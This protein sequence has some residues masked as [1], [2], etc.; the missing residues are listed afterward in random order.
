[1]PQLDR[2]IVFTQIFWLFF[3]FAFLYITLTHFFLPTFLKSIK[4]RKKVV[5]E[6]SKEVLS[7][8]SSLVLKQTLLKQTLLKTLASMGDTSMKHSISVSPQHS[9]TDTELV[10]KKIGQAS[11]NTALYCSNHLLNSIP[12]YPK[13]FNLDCK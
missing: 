8:D 11:L 7:I 1:M 9:R 12:L 3:I 4:S 5:D 6:N 10:S 2:I 13:L